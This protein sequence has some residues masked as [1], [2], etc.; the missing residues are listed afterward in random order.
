MFYP[1]L[2]N[3]NA[4]NTSRYVTVA[5]I[6]NNQTNTVK[7]STKILTLRNLRLPPELK[8][9]LPSSRLLRRVRWFDV[10]VSEVPVGPIS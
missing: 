1:V 5:T 4:Q 6:F 10:D 3:T 7:T 8:L 9:I 2:V